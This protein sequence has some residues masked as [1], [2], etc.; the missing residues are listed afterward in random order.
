[1]KIKS[2]L[3]VFIVAVTLVLVCPVFASAE[4]ENAGYTITSYDVDIKVNENNT[5]EV[6]ETIAV[7][8]TLE[9]RGIF[10]S[11]PV[12]PTV[13][14]QNGNEVIEKTY[15]VIVS[16]VT[17]NVPYE[18]EKDG[19]YVVLRLGDEDKYITGPMQY[20]ISFLYD[21]GDD[22]IAGYD[23]FYY[24]ILG[25]ETNTT[26]ENVNFTFTMPKEF[27]AS[28]LGFSVGAK[29]SSGYNPDNFSFEVNGNVVTGVFTGMLYPYESI[30]A[31]MELPAGYFVNMRQ[32]GDIARPF[33]IVFLI[34]TAVIVVLAICFGRKQRVIQTVEFY[35]PEGMT[36]AD[37]GF[38]MD[39]TA[40]N[41]DLIALLIYW[42]DGGYIEIREM[43]KKDME[44]TKIKDLPASANDYETLMFSRMFVK[45]DT[46][47]VKDLQYEFYDTLNVAKKRV[48]AK[49]ETGENTVFKKKY[50]MLSDLAKMLSAVPVAAMTMLVTYMET[51]ESML[52]LIIGITIFFVAY[53]SARV[54]DLAIARWRSEK[55]A[56]KVGSII[57]WVVLTAVVYGILLFVASSGMFFMQAILAVCCSFVMMVLAPL[58][59]KR[60]DK[61]L[62][63]YGRILGLKEFINTVEAKKLEMM[64]EEDPQYFYNVL[65]YAYVLGVSDKWAKRFESI[66]VEPPNWY[67]GYNMSTFSTVY[68][69]S[70]MVRSMARSQ[71]YMAATKSNSGGGGNFGGGGFSGGGFS[72]GGF[73][74]GG[75]GRW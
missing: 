46:T 23:M 29:G 16:N 66:A 59:K 55:R 9:S 50:Q 41:K 75:V 18:V 5:Y 47:S 71:A 62:I 26:V 61:G 54:F 19:D 73:G 1:M 43:E 33:T 65:P 69:T 30:T 56:T 52:V 34:M 13:T 22:R 38:V 72:G 64:V 21:A 3:I 60:T 10:R 39:G 25:G 7:D 8:F 42:A 24:D 48:K 53:G 6:K 63:W 67:Y 14:W 2:K 37:V 44:L 70:M 68:F 32:P 31:R 74:G 58:F 36:P 40:D 45:G 57:A 28:K 12:R 20:E 11:I 27:D 4:A 35:A 51:Y 49:Y 17:V 15:D